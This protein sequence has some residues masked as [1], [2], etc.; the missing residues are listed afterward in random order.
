[1]KETRIVCGVIST[2]HAKCR[3]CD[4]LI[5]RGEERTVLKNIHVSPKIRD[6]HFHTKC[7]WFLLKRREINGG[8]NDG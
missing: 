2:A 3:L 7:F 4:T 6:L 5:D 8:K 1:M